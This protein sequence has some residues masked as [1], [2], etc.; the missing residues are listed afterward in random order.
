[1]VAEDEEAL[2]SAASPGPGPHGL[3]NRLCY[4]GQAVSGQCR[5]AEAELLFQRALA[6]IEGSQSPETELTAFVLE[7]YARLFRA[8]GRA[9]E[10]GE[11]E[12]RAQAVRAQA[13]SLRASA[14]PSA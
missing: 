13:A 14:P 4:L 10:A 9:V 5:H 3:A 1:M 12:A 6:L 8:T 7:P 2:R 11:M